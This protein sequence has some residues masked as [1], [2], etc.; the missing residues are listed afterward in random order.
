MASV[1]QRELGEELWRL[2]K[3]IDQALDHLREVA[4]AYSV[5]EHNYRQARAS[6]WMRTHGTISD[7]EAQVELRCGDLRH[8][9]DTAENLKAA[10]MESLRARRAQLSALQSL[11]GAARAEAE[12]V[13]TG[14]HDR[15]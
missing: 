8:E 15:P 9:R 13:R 14:P 11:M 12:F 2:T 6:A 1:N 3:V 10:A 7:R 4:V 5:A